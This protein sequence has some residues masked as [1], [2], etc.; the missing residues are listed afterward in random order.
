M[1]IQMDELSTLTM[2]VLS[3]HKHHVCYEF[4][5]N[6]GLAKDSI[7]NINIF[8]LCD[9]DSTVK[10]WSWRECTAL[11]I[12]AL[13]TVPRCSTKYF[14]STPLKTW[15]WRSDILN[16]SVETFILVTMIGK[17]RGRLC[18]NKIYFYYNMYWYPVHQSR[19]Y[20]IKWD[21]SM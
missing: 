18:K 2:E 15:E 6:S 10:S 1:A 11:Y 17:I 9:V 3:W 20:K 16:T 7:Y 13:A 21:E 8:C 5:W 19:T 14:L 4:L 12:I